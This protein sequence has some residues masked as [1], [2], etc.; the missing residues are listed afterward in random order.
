M[1]VSTKIAN[2]LNQEHI[3]IKS[4]EKLTKNEFIDR[5]KESDN[6]TLKIASQKMAQYYNNDV[7]RQLVI[8]I[9]DGDKLTINKRKYNKQVYKTF[10]IMLGI[11][12]RYSKDGEFFYIPINYLASCA[13]TTP[14]TAK[15]AINTALKYNV[16]HFV[17]YDKSHSDFA[18]CKFKL[19]NKKL[20]EKWIEHGKGLH[21]EEYDTTYISNQM[22]SNSQAVL[23]LNEDKRVKDSLKAMKDCPYLIK[24]FNE[25]NVYKGDFKQKFLLDGRLRASS[26]FTLT[27][28]PENHPEIDVNLF[29]RQK[30]LLE[31]QKKLGCD[32]Y[33]EYDINAS[34]YTLSYYIKN[35]R[36][37]EKDFYDLFTL[38][39]KQTYHEDKEFK[40]LRINKE[41]RKKIKTFC[42]RIYMHGYNP[43]GKGSYVGTCKKILMKDNKLHNSTMV[44][45]ITYIDDIYKYITGKNIEDSD[46]IC[47]AYVTFYKNAYD[48]MSNLCDI[49]R[50]KIFLYETLLCSLL[51]KM[52]TEKGI[53]IVNAYDG[54]YM[55]SSFISTFKKELLPKAYK[56]VREVYYKY[57][58]K[59][60]REKNKELLDYLISI[61]YIYEINNRYYVKIKDIYIDFYN[62]DIVR[63]I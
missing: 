11:I 3:P 36:F 29:E 62:Y 20:L 51:I 39:L 41:L 22:V 24:A 31:L 8:N 63:I 6:I 47:N 61:G 52:G 59:S 27:K 16:I 58:N 28:N 9:M 44:K 57:Q 38:Q 42:M 53:Q 7:K 13:E 43:I 18:M 40:T 15:K 2:A 21:N 5:F 56:E 54:F 60:T 4:I 30:L 25:S 48:I 35:G 32:E 37:P 14:R 26:K 10:C 33:T 12:N 45:E 46:D 17:G 23:Q 49:K 34:I 50:S 1:I 55:P 19:V